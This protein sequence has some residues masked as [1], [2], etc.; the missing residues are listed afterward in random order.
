MRRTPPLRGIRALKPGANC[1]IISE[2]W[3]IEGGGEITAPGDTD[4]ETLKFFKLRPK[5]CVPVGKKELLKKRWIGTRNRVEGECW[6]NASSRFNHFPA[7]PPPFLFPPGNLC[8]SKMRLS[9]STAF[10]PR[11][12]K[13]KE[14]KYPELKKTRGSSGGINRGGSDGGDD[15][16]LETIRW[17]N[18]LHDVGATLHKGRFTALAFRQGAITR[19][20]PCIRTSYSCV[21]RRLQD[22]SS[23]EGLVEEGRESRRDRRRRG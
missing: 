20:S 12:E 15:Y 21:L 9:N 2:R 10:F 4:R 18:L 8:P 14:R 19:S 13:E 7:S 22:S 6:P 3:L 11:K 23:W 5:L 16:A 17:I 1:R